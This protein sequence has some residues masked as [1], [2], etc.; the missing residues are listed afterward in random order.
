[1]SAVNNATK[2]R[3]RPFQPGVSGNARGRPKGAMNTRTRAVIEAAQNG[4]EMP[5][6]YMLKVMRDPKADHRR[7]DAMAMAAAPYL[8]PRLNPV[9]PKLNNLLIEPKRTK[10]EIMFVDP[11]A[12]HYTD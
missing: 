5:L 7:R 6:D 4:G 12:D 11:A 9:D 1:M 8:H 10:L 2:Q 3:G